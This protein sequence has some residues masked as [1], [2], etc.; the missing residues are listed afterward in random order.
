MCQHTCADCPL[1]PVSLAGM[2]EEAM[3]R[4]VIEL[5]GVGHTWD[6]PDIMQGVQAIFYEDDCEVSAS[7][8]APEE[9]MAKALEMMGRRPPVVGPSKSF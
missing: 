7:G 2:F 3:A 9:A 6:D 8:D 1:R 5:S 4:G